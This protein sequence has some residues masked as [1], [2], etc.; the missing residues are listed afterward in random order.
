MCL[1]LHMPTC[2]PAYIHLYAFSPICTYAFS[3]YMYMPSLLYTCTSTPIYL[4]AFIFVF[5]FSVTCFKPFIITNTS[6]QCILFI[7]QATKHAHPD[8]VE[9]LCMIT[10]IEGDASTKATKEFVRLQNAIFHCE[11]DIVLNAID[12]P[13]M[14]CCEYGF[15]FHCHERQNLRAH[16]LILYNVQ[17]LPQIEKSL[18]LPRHVPCHHCILDRKK[19]S[20]VHDQHLPLRQEEKVAE[21]VFRWQHAESPETRKLAEEEARGYGVKPYQV[22]A[23]WNRGKLYASTNAYDP[24]C[25]PSDI[26]HGDSLGTFL[27][28]FQ[29]TCIA[30][31][32]KPRASRR[33][34]ARAVKVCS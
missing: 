22:S 8:S 32:N 20:M 6:S 15:M 4:P 26:L 16:P 11:M 12:N 1:P 23:F 24:A 18:C 27:Q 30:I 9:T 14:Q 10:L 7:L 33:V 19:H 5:I 31:R 3:P 13:D 34:D 17:D 2:I 21:I 28:H 29:N 25:N